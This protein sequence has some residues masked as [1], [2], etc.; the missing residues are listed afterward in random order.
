MGMMNYNA[1]DLD[2]SL[3]LSRESIPAIGS[4]IKIWWIP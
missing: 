1:H 2:Y 3:I 4:L